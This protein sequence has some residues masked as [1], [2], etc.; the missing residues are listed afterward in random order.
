MLI[1]A[2]GKTVYSL[3]KFTLL[4]MIGPSATVVVSRFL[5]MPDK[6]FGNSNSLEAFRCLSM[7]SIY[8]LARDVYSGIFSFYAAQPLVIMI[9]GP[10]ESSLG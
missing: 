6:P 4:I 9:S 5:S 1:S 10:F 2:T 7:K 8:Y 3:V